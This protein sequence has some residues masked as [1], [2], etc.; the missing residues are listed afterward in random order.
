MS[1]TIGNAKG[2]QLQGSITFH[3]DLVT[4]RISTNNQYYITNFCD[5]FSSFVKTVNK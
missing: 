4:K 3:F 1:N 5:T 2:D